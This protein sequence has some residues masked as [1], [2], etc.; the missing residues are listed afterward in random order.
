MVNA[1][2]VPF[3]RRITDSCFCNQN[4]NV[5]TVVNAQSESVPMKN[6]GV[7]LAGLAMA[8]FLVG[9]GLVLGRRK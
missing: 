4:R 7:P 8:F 9:S 6:T 1:T 5:T 3:N 2:S